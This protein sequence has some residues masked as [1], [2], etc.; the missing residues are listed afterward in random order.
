MKIK[1]LEKWSFSSL[2]TQKFFLIFTL[3]ALTYNPFNFNA[4]LFHLKIKAKELPNFGQEIIYLFISVW[5]LL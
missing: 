1:K 2:T 4:F 3:K 5:S